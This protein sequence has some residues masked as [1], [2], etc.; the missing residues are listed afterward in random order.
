MFRSANTADVPILHTL[1]S[2][3]WYETY[4]DI[5]T[6]DEIH[7][8]IETFYNTARISKEVTKFS[9]DWLGYFIL[10]VNDKIVGCIGGGIV[11]DV[12]HIYVLYLEVDEKRKGYGTILVEEFTRIQQ[13]DY[14]IN[15]QEL[16]VTVGN[17]SGLKFYESLGFEVKDTKPMHGF[18]NAL[19]YKSY[20][21]TRKL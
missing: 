12:G 18:N 8:V 11:G 20:T 4:K 16:S 7:E 3:A 13:I 2:T 5:Y 9:K 15:T 6:P 10:E 14:P 1:L 17:D 21:M 19:N